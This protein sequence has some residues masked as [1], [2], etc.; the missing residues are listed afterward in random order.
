MSYLT[1]PTKTLADVAEAQISANMGLPIVEA[2]GYEALRWAIP[3]P[4]VDGRWAF[5][6]PDTEYL[7]G[8][9]GFG[10]EAAPAF[11]QVEL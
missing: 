6:K 1:F 5:L 3:S 2:N 4:L 8:V 10:E 11:V 7:S 9:S